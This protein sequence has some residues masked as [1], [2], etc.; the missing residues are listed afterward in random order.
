MSSSG[1][2]LQIAAGTRLQDGECVRC[3]PSIHEAKSTVAQRRPQL[4]PDRRNSE[5][6]W[7]TTLK[8]AAVVQPFGDPC[9]WPWPPRRPRSQEIDPL[10]RTLSNCECGAHPAMPLSLSVEAAV[11]LADQG[12]GDRRHIDRDGAFGGNIHIRSGPAW[13]GRM[14]VAG[15]VW[16]PAT[17]APGRQSAPTA[18]DGPSTPSRG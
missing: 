2:S 17:P 18:P 14:A 3:V 4:P 5:R 10:W 9:F 11:P 8:H 15:R 7:S 13:P 16:Q 6:V 1:T 12:R